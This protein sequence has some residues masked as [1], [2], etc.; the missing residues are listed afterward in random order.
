MT[1]HSVVPEEVASRSMFPAD[2]PANLQPLAT[3]AQALN[4]S[5]T[6]ETTETKVGALTEALNSLG[7][8]DLSGNMETVAPTEE[9]LSRGEERAKREM[10]EDE[11]C[12]YLDWQTESFVPPAVSN[13]DEVKTRQ[14]ESLKRAKEFPASPNDLAALYKV[15]NLN[16][17]KLAGW[18][19]NPSLSTAEARASLKA[20]GRVR[21]VRARVCKEQGSQG[22][23]RAISGGPSHR[24]TDQKTPKKEVRVL[25]GVLKSVRVFRKDFRSRMVKVMRLLEAVERNA[26]SKLD[27]HGSQGGHR[28]GNNPIRHR[29][30][31]G[32]CG[33]EIVP[34]TDMMESDA[35]AEL[36]ESAVRGQTSPPTESAGTRE[37]ETM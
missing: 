4:A 32:V 28:R 11:R 34:P 25:K 24:G 22:S 21:R 29:G 15:S 26:K 35:A 14:P 5:D 20:I 31:I 17:P 27:G 3:R 8:R 12:H 7:A 23:A 9:M 33:G 16:L 1:T 6:L 2:L 37:D 19:D 13:W 18:L 36:G 10:S 30:I